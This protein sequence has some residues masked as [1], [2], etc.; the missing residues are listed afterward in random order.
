M[1]DDYQRKQTLADAER[2]ITPALKEYEEK[3]LGAEERVVEIEYD[4]FQEVRRQ[5]AAHGA[6][7]Q[8]TADALATLDVL[9]G[10]GRPGPRPQFLRAAD[11]RRPPI[12]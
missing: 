10:P 7:I 9:A 6:R 2:F 3:V 5:V 11:G 12:C 4:L 1:P 8:A